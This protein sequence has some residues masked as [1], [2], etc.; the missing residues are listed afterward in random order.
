MTKQTQIT[1][2]AV[3]SSLRV[4]EQRFAEL[5]GVDSSDTASLRR[6]R[7][8]F[9]VDCIR[10]ANQVAEFGKYVLYLNYQQGLWRDAVDEETGEPYT[11][12]MD[13]V[14]KFWQRN[15][16]E[17]QRRTMFADFSK[18]RQMQQIGVDAQ[19]QMNLV[20]RAPYVVGDL[21]DKAVV[22][23]AAG[24]FVRLDGEYRERIESEMESSLGFDRAEMGEMSDPDL[25]AQFLEVLSEQDSKN[26]I[27]KIKARV[28]REWLRRESWMPQ[29]GLVRWEFFQEDA[30][31]QNK[32]TVYLRPVAAE[33]NKQNLSE[34]VVRR[35]VRNLIDGRTSRV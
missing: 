21:L 7:E 9:A 31:G 14:V 11:N 24:N 25:M 19:A 8:D 4:I 2:A 13:Y 35:H 23:D 17:V 30:K 15:V 10:A 20:A 28:T 26:E 18:Y 29:E 16:E 6:K 22:T 27:R 34:P 1:V 33:Q 5:L 3:E 32:V 12:G